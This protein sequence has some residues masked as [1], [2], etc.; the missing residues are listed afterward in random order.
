MVSQ[1]PIAVYFHAACVTP[2]GELSYFGGLTSV[3]PNS[4]T[5]KLF[6]VWIDIPP[7]KEMAWRALLF[8]DNQ[9]LKN[10]SDTELAEFGLPHTYR[11]RL[12]ND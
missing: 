5:R 6:S 8:Y 9:K 10:K 4:R 3:G 11:Q 12:R 1:I 7:L 2:H